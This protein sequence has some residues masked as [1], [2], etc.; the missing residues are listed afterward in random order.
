MKK[1]KYKKNNKKYS[2]KVKKIGFLVSENRKTR[3][4]LK[5]NNDVQNLR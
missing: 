4:D 5:I 2:L 1:M 3:H